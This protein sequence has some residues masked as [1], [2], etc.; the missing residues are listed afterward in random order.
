VRAD[1]CLQA[2]ASLLT[3]SELS[4]PQ[5]SDLKNETTVFSYD[6]IAGIMNTGGVLASF[7]SL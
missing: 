3:D 1:P 5:S 7:L 6:M 4:G 2:S